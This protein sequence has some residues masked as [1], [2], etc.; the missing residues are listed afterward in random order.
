ML[1]AGPG[2]AQADAGS[3]YTH[4]QAERRGRIHQGVSA[5]HKQRK[6]RRPGQ[7]NHERAPELPAA[8]RR[9]GGGP[10][11]SRPGRDTAAAGPGHQREARPV[12]L[13]GLAGAPR[14]VIRQRVANLDVIFAIDDSGS[15]HGPD[16]TDP[17]GARNA[18]CL[19]VVDL[20]QRHG[21]GRAGVVHWGDTAPASMA[22]APM[23]VYRGR[24]RRGLRI[25]PILGG[26]QPAGGTGQGAQAHPGD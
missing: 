1:P 25:Q 11:C 7:V 12:R 2:R 22:L 9:P 18:A 4:V 21:G 17:G 15:V 19:S 23:P 3:T 24:L 10:A 6:R 26:T 13:P 20:M 14:T 16:G 5:P 8:R